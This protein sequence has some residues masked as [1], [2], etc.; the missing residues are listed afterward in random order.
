MFKRLT[1]L[2]VLVLMVAALCA[3]CSGDGTKAD[4]KPD[5]PR[6]NNGEPV[7]LTICIYGITGN[8]NTME[9]YVP[10]NDPIR[11]LIEE[12]T[13]TKITY[14]SF[15]VISY[16]DD[17]AAL[18]ASGE[19]PPDI[20]QN[21][22]GKGETG[23][24]A[25]NGQ[26]V[27]LA[28]L[29]A[30][31]ADR[32]PVLASIMKD[33]IYRLY[34][35]MY[36]GDVDKA[37]GFYTLFGSTMFN[38]Y[39]GDMVYNMNILRKLG[40][41]R[42]PE[43]IEQF[44]EY[45]KAASQNGIIAWYPRNW[46][47]QNFQSMN[48]SAL[49]SF[50][51][52]IEYPD[53]NNPWIGMRQGTDGAWSCV[54]TSDASKEAVKVLRDMYADGV[55]PKEIGSMP[56]FDTTI[57]AWKNDEIGCISYYCT[58]AYQYQWALDT[59]K[60]AHPDADFSDITLGT[61][62]T[63]ASG[64][65]GKQDYLSF[66]VAMNWV[67]PQASAEKAPAILDLINF[68]GS[69]EGQD[70]VFNGIEGLHYTVDDS[71]GLVFNKE[72]WNK[73][74]KMFGYEDNRCK[75]PGFDFMYSAAE[76]RGNDWESDALWIDKSADLKDY[77]AETWGYSDDFL[78]AK[79]ITDKIQTEVGNKLP[80]YFVFIS[81]TQESMDIRANLKTVSLEYLPAFVKGEKDIDAEWGDYVKAYE[82]AGI[83][84]FT[85]D[86]NAQIDVAKQKYEAVSKF[87][88]VLKN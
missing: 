47:F 71:G 87:S 23:T 24:W 19:N 73:I 22:G 11:A 18:M 20:I 9:Y 83:Q 64:K 59:Y 14:T 1:S 54:T 72:E 69:K 52:A 35:E 41:D 86:F 30:A 7:E 17:L 46:N 57:E 66:Y 77:T 58:N 13:N 79:D 42:P 53:G 61:P 44:M 31:D 60:E 63:D 65:L 75:Y 29:V 12:K 26:L 40:F 2:F 78:K 27:D 81:L 68:I 4:I 36:S 25:S 10:E 33:P 8:S 6:P 37:Y 51:T 43:T 34:N 67:V 3:G 84:K 62:L 49:G 15:P 21:W 48:Y 56:D 74:T 50:N 45:G 16:S 85:D 88:F 38:N 70:I 80:P 55:L 39:V 5:N 76:L 82:D 28:A 32:Y